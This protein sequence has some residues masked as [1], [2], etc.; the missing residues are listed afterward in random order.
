MTLIGL[1]FLVVV[2]TATL[3]RREKQDILDQKVLTDQ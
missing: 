3:D 2:E 1:L